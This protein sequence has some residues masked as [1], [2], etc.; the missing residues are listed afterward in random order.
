MVVNPW[1]KL[2]EETVAVGMVEKFKQLSEFGYWDMT[3]V[4][5]QTGVFWIA[6]NYCCVMFN[7]ADIKWIINTT[8][9]I[10]DAW[11][12]NAVVSE[13]S[14]CEIVK[15]LCWNVC[16]VVFVFCRLLLLVLQVQKVHWHQAQEVSLILQRIM[17]HTVDHSHRWVH[18]FCTRLER[19]FK[20]C[21]SSAKCNM[22]CGMP[23]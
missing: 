17:L 19:Y 2:D 15:D 11:I 10:L 8:N 16:L 13:C 18:V 14:H 12:C 1:N 3:V 6:L 5:T 20:L 4:L 7:L 9:Y 22:R 23:R 21:F